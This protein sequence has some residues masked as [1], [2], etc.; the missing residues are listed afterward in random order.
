MWLCICKIM[1]TFGLS[2]L[3]TSMIMAYFYWSKYSYDV[4]ISYRRVL[5]LISTVLFPLGVIFVL[6]YYFCLVGII[7]GIAVSAAGLIG[8]SGFI[9]TYLKYGKP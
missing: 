7:P 3:I 4:D 5:F 1:L 9:H 8:T 2:S 6:P